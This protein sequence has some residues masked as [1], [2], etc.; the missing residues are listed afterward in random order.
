MS[1]IECF[2]LEPTDLACRSLR[3]YVASLDA[4]PKD[5]CPLTLGYHN[6]RTDIGEVA[7]G[8]TS[9]T[10]GR[11][12][13]PEDVRND[14]RWPAACA[15]GYLFLETDQFQDSHHT[16]FRRSDTGEL[17]T[18]DRAPVGAM[19]NADWMGDGY[20]G[21]DGLYLCVRTPGG[22]WAI[23][24]PATDGGR[25]TR[26]GKPPQV[27]ARPSICAGKNKDGGWIYHG[28]L[29]NGQLREC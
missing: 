9:R 29:T 16:L 18:L 27:T 26:S 2:W 17:T 25:W 12:F 8:A 22:T 4:E 24:G 7:D 21:P 19:W 13:M 1:I 28:F 3:R 11:D 23:D 10:G 14:P 6:N 15:C 5:P 20:K